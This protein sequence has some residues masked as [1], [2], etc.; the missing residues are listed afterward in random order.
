MKYNYNEFTFKAHSKDIY[1][2]IDGN[3]K[4]FFTDQSYQ[5][6]S[7]INIYKKSFNKNK[8]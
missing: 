1:F 3:E 6:S 5:I 8:K 4:R 7:L 2:F